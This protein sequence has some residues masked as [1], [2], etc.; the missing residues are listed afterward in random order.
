MK[1]SI[2][3]FVLCVL[4]ASVVCAENPSAAR[5]EIT[6]YTKQQIISKIQ[7]ATAPRVEEN[8]LVFTAEKTARFVGIAFDF[9]NFRIIH[10]F[11]RLQHYEG[12]ETPVDSV[13]FYVT[14]Y[15]KELTR[16][17]Y[18]LII[19]GLWTVDPLNSET[20]FDPKT[21]ALLSTVSIDSTPAP[22]TEKIANGMVR[23]VYYGEGGQ[24]I[25]LGGTFNNWDPFM[26]TMTEVASGVYQ[27][28]LPLPKGTY[29][30]NFY[31]GTN[32][33]IDAK[34]PDRVFTGDGKTASL[35]LVD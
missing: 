22:V 7:H 10:P 6:A 25:R 5:D 17:S 32:S 2:F 19:D 21:N 30:Y 18:R 34:N 3:F 26:Y 12:D 11:E 23:F 1:R 24:K 31:N 33:L 27:I 8:F 16:I 14:Q 15:P 13:L 20:V 29:Y 28:D 9:E 35:L 4:C